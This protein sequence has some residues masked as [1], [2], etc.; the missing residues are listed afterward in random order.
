MGYLPFII[1]NPNDIYTW[2][3]LTMKAW[4]PAKVGDYHL[5]RIGKAAALPR[6]EG[7]QTP[8]NGCVNASH[9]VLFLWGLPGL[10]L[11]FCSGYWQA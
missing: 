9:A 6:G 1:L 2:P 4:L 7:G 10:V 5:D 8:V 11:L 3:P